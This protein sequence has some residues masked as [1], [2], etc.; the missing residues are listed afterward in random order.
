MTEEIIL[1]Y[2]FK[3]IDEPEHSN[4][5]RY[6]LKHGEFD[7]PSKHAPLEH[8]L[9]WNYRENHIQIRRCVYGL[10]FSPDQKQI[11]FHGLCPTENDF[12]KILE[13]TE[14]LKLV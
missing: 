4:I 9:D 13:L 5:K 8:E 12:I 3:F 7:V 14:I 10:L 6:V 11:I 2:R 1:K